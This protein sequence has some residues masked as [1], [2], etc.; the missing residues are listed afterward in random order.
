MEHFF[1]NFKKDF[2]INE[3]QSSVAAIKAE[4]LTHEIDVNDLSLMFNCIDL[5]SLNSDD[6]TY[7]IKEFC[8]KANDFGIEFPN[9]K[10]VA[11]VCVYPVFAPVLKTSL[12]YPGIKKAVVAG[13]FPSSQTFTDIKVAETKR[14]IEFGADEID[15]VISIG[16]FL[17]ENYEFILEEIR[18]IKEASKNAHLKVILETGLLSDPEVIWKASLL[19]MEG[20]ADFIKTSTGKTTV[21]ATPEAAYIMC[22]AIKAFYKQSGKKI[23]FKAAG[24]ISTSTDAIVYLEIV[25]RVLGSEWANNELFRIG[26]SRLANQLLSDLKTIETGTA[27]TIHYF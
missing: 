13:G 15:M 24:G 4:L 6:S 16:E 22:Q 23:G 25:R 26:A 7:L 9:Y 1:A 20:G 3:V 17:D 21:S 14:A 2:D 5:T 8:E 18:M 10:S 19:A 11:A 12:K 27:Q